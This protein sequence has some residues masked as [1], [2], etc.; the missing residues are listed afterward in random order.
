MLHEWWRKKL[1]QRRSRRFR[2][3]LRIPEF[4]FLADEELDNDEVYVSLDC[5]TTGLNP[6]KDRIITL[7]AVKIVGNRILSSQ[8]FTAMI[9]PQMT[10]SEQSI[11]IHHIRHA[12]L[13]ACEVLTERQALE[14]FLT[15]IG[16]ATLIG[17]YLEFDLA[18]LDR[19]VKPW[20]GDSLP[21]PRIE[22]SELFYQ[23]R[24][25]QSRDSMRNAHIDLRF[26]R[27]MDDLQLPRFSQHDAFNDALM[28]AMAFVKLRSLLERERAKR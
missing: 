3:R 21:N 5:E 12:D 4:A 9:D 20:L 8:K 25:Q 1:Q 14:A 27:M 28:T 16:S 15:F 19:L 6:K 22:V 23:W 17:Y 7:S 10:I 13:Q 2:R 18:M 24:Q 11:K 26:D